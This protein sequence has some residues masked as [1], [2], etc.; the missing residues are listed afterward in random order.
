M[1]DILVEAC[2]EFIPQRWRPSSSLFLCQEIGARV[3]R[4]LARSSALFQRMLIVGQALEPNATVG[5][6]GSAVRVKGDQRVSGKTSGVARELDA[7]P[8]P[9]QGD[10]RTSQRGSG[11]GGEI[12]S[13]Q[14]RLFVVRSST[15]ESSWEIAGKWDTSSRSPFVRLTPRPWVVM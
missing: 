12:C 1:C 6:S 3:L 15:M 11:G 14:K 13:R 2:V 10:C 8:T 5:E 7:P 4:V 9:P